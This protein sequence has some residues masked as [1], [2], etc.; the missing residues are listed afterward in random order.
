MSPIKNTPTKLNRYLRYAEEHLGV[1][2]A[3]RHEFSLASH[4]YGPDILEEVADNDLITCGLTAGDAIRLKR[5]ASKWWK[6][7]EAKRRKTT[8]DDEY[9]V[10][11]EVPQESYNRSDYSIRFEKRFHTGGS[12]SLFGSGITP[13]RVQKSANFSWYYFNQVTRRT[14]PVPE[15][16]VPILDPVEYP[17]NPFDNNDDDTSQSSQVAEKNGLGDSNN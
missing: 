7:P 17:I 14:E 13:G 10:L 11:S 12:H 3:T 6:G 1:K 15:G 2:N 8:A 9:A 5:G 16:H 4:G